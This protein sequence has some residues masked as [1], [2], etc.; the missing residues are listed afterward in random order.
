MS[1]SRFFVPTGEKKADDFSLGVKPHPKGWRPSRTE[2]YDGWADALYA[3]VVGDD[4]ETTLNPGERLGDF[5]AATGAGAARGLVNIAGLPGTVHDLITSGADLALE[6][7]LGVQPTGHKSPFSGAALNEKLSDLTGGASARRGESTLANYGSTAGEYT[8][9][10]MA[11]GAPALKFGVAPAIASETAGKLTEGSPLEPYARLGAGLAT[12]FALNKAAKLFTPHPLGKGHMDTTRLKFAKDLDDAGIPVSA[13]QKTGDIGLQLKEYNTPFYPKHLEAQNIAFTKAVGKSFG[14][15]DDLLTPDVMDGARKRIGKV[16]EEVSAKT[17]VTF[18]PAHVRRM[19]LS[20]DRYAKGIETPHLVGSVKEAWR[21]VNRAQKN[22]L[23]IGGEKWHRMRSD[24]GRKL[25]S[26]DASTRDVAREMID[27]LDDAMEASAVQLGNPQFAKEFAV[28]RSDWRNY[29]AV[30]RALEYGGG[31][32]AFGVITPAAF[33]SALR[34][35]GGDSFSLAN[36]GDLSKITRA[37]HGILRPPS[38]SGTAQHADAL[39]LGAKNLPA[40]AAG[41]AAGYALAGTP[42]AII[43]GAIGQSAPTL[44]H[45]GMYGSKLGQLYMGNQLMRPEAVVSPTTAA[46][47]LDRIIQELTKKRE[48]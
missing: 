46:V 43:G 3:N 33:K 40:T 39:N 30:K 37:G 1:G 23:P 6:K 42:G 35:Q 5:I 17:P 19:S 26:T 27:V 45:R 14:V 22:G 47:G 18:D 24:L 4:D 34:T 32:T 41:S 38:S 44:L 48:N 10:A 9:G 31:D 20:I 29:L 8:A 36:R 11:F 15:T 28:A 2:P 25:K 7:G 12:P 13:G 16:F 21:T